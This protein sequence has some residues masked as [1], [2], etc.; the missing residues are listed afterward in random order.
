MG[1]RFFT[2]LFIKDRIMFYSFSDPTPEHLWR[3]RQRWEELPDK[4]S[5]LNDEEFKFLNISGSNE[6]GAYYLN[7]SNG[8]Y[9]PRMRFWGNKPIAE[10]RSFNNVTSL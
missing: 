2:N 4:N 5:N 3:Y 1:K 7:M 8:F 9:T 6:E 10:N